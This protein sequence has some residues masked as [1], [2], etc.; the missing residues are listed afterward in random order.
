MTQGNMCVF[1]PQ[2]YWYNLL[3]LNLLRSS[4][5]QQTHIGFLSTKHELYRQVEY[6]HRGDI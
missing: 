6:T 4:T 5:F 1:L 3:N 2:A